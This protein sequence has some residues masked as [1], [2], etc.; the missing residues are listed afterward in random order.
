M[1][2]IKKLA[3]QT[4]IYGFSS[5]IGRFLN[6]LLTPL[7]TWLVFDP[8]EF[9]VVTEL[10]A[11]V[12]FLLIFLTYGMETG[13]FRFMQNENERNVVFPTI[14]ITLL[15]TSAFFILIVFVFIA[16]ISNFLEYQN[17]KEYI[18][19]LAVIVAIDA[20]TSIPYAKL[21]YEN[22]ALRFATFKLI[23]ICTNIGFNVLFLIVFPHLSIKY[24]FN[25][26]EKYFIR[27]NMIIYVFISN[28]IASVVTLILFIPE[29]LKTKLIYSYRLIL[30]VL[31]YSFPL[32]LA[33]LA[34]QT[35]EVL[36]RLLLKHFIIVPDGVDNSNAYIMA[37]IGIY[38]ANFKLAVIMTLFIQAF[39]YAFEPMFF[40]QANNADSKLLYARIMKFFVIFCL[41]VFLLITLFLDIFKYLIGN[42]FHS[43]LHIIP[44]VLF[45]N[46]FLG[47]LYNLS[48]WYK[49]TDK[50]KFGLVIAAFGAAVTIIFNLILIPRYGYTGSAW[51]HLICYTCMI[52]LSY[53]LM[54]KYYFI[55]YDLKDIGIYLLV[56][57]GLFFI[58][59]FIKFEITI[60]KYLFHSFLL[61]CFIIFVVLKEGI[62]KKFLYNES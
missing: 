17:F 34:G 40:G 24:N 11:Y 50:T 4:A 39:R 31:P 27:D 5:L 6:Y 61:I 42:K 10:Y 56:G 47:I 52:L 58:G 54:R 57:L 59:Y 22:K 53:L 15:F 2:P 36:D 48:L 21:R 60:L 33:G 8:A 18:L 41:F 37:Q 38:G 62:Y 49:I 35:N 3:G 45:A 44:V 30:K 9:G 13:Y 14:L 55:S 46:I 16:P 12:V 29:F 32:L 25:C 51:I 28:L 20:F 23:N 19:I 43:G 1:N 26:I 7:Y